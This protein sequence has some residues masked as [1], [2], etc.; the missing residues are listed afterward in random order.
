MD[1]EIIP[2]HQEIKLRH[3]IPGKYIET[4]VGSIFYI[5]KE[6]DIKTYSKKGGG[7]VTIRQFELLCGNC[8]QPKNCLVPSIVAKKIRCL[9]CAKIT[10]ADLNN[11]IAVGNVI[12]NRYN[13]KFLIDKFL[14]EEKV[15]LKT[16]TK[17]RYFRTYQL[18]CM[19][20][21]TVSIVTNSAI[22]NGAATCRNC[23]GIKGESAIK[24][25]TA[26]RKLENVDEIDKIWEQMLIMSKEG[27]LVD[28][29]LNKFKMN[30]D[31]I[32]EKEKSKAIEPEP[33]EEDEYDKE[34]EIDD[35]IEDLFN[36]Y[37]N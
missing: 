37:E 21:Q 11:E 33:S 23:R 35:D 12:R 19:K 32:G 24:N 16:I 15:A 7:L 17:Y 25:I 28:Y 3:I 14:T 13:E 2:K 4:Y 29:L 30:H 36:E 6:I 34:I 31:D 26:E 20:C 27:T 1:K 10:K 18:T 5:N 9:A 8:K 22:W